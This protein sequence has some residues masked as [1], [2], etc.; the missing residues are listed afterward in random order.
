MARQI[1]RR[2]KSAT[3]AT[4]QGGLTSPAQ[5][6]VILTS[7]S[8]QAQSSGASQI[9]VYVEYDLMCCSQGTVP[10]AKPYGKIMWES[11]GHL[12]IQNRC[13]HNVQRLPLRSC[14]VWR[15]KAYQIT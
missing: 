11:L 8:H 2:D 12:R 15:K 13:I 1:D 7:S 6:T 5:P 4:Q 3:G 9:K 10:N 14:D